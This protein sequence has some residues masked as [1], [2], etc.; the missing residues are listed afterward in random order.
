MNQQAPAP[1][2]WWLIWATITAA[3]FAAVGI[4]E[5]TGIRTGS[6]PWTAL[7]VLPLFIA[8]AFIRF[9]LLPRVT[10]PPKKFLFFILGLACAESGGFLALVLGSAWK[11]PLAAAALVLMIVH[12]PAFIRRD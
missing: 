7:V 2:V 4:F 5:T 3:F 10:A 1:P 9:G 8:S 12:V 6:P 11:T